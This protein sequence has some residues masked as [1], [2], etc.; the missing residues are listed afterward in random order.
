MTYAFIQAIERG[1]AST[2]G[3]ML[4]AMRS[5]IRNTDSGLGGGIVTS[6]ISMLLTGGSLG[7]LRQ[8]WFSILSF[9]WPDMRKC[10]SGSWIVFQ[11]NGFLQ[12][13]FLS[14]MPCLCRFQLASLTSLWMVFAAG[15]TANRQWNIWCVYKT[16]LPVGI[17]INIFILLV[18]IIIQMCPNLPV[19][20]CTVPWETQ[21]CHLVVLLYATV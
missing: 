13:C 6:L 7:G 21:F 16:F 14:L 1:H 8:V 2:Y 19:V 5:T 10:I 17:K 11:F 12:L 20:L 9:V 15:T 18:I 3:N 4:N